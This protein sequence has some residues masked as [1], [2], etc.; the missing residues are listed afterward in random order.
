MLDVA[1]LV[2]LALFMSVYPGYGGQRF[3]PE[4]LDNVRAFKRYC[5]DNRLD[6]L[7]QIDGGINLETAPRAVAAGVNTIV[8]GTFIFKSA[9]YGEAL[10]LLREACAAVKPDY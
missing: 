9:D 5:V 8:A 4:V 7:I 3:I 10:R 6:P 1:H 2:D